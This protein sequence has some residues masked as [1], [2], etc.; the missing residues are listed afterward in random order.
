MTLTGTIL[1]ASGRSTDFD[2]W[3]LHLPS[4]KLVQLTQ[5]ANYNDSPRCSPNGAQI[6]YISVLED[7]I[8]SLWVMD[9][10]GHNK[11]QL[12]KGIYCQHPSWSPDGTKILFTGNAA[13][14]SEIEVCEIAVTGGKPVPL[15][16]RSGIESHPS[17]SPDG[18]TI[19]FAALADGKTSNSDIFEYS[20]SNKTFKQLASHPLKDY[21]PKY[22]PDGK[23]IAFIS[24]RNETTEEQHRTLLE[25]AAKQVAS[26]DMKAL[27]DSIRALQAIESD[28]DIFTMNRDGSDLQQITH[29]SKA[30]QHVSWSPCGKYLVYTSTS[31]KQPQ[32]KRLKVIDAHTGDSCEIDYDRT[33]LKRETGSTSAVNFSIF[34]RVVPDC[35][36]RLFADPSFWGEERHP[37]WIR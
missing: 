28:G 34:Q 32:S 10:D 7:S 6:V 14:P 3:S 27:N 35:I 2:I 12:T 24:H 33:S 21:G 25:T 4:R 8:P 15:F 37:C 9:V 30:D 19:L 16:K 20:P 18:R 36:E 22:S 23:K 17:W 26:G 5:G 11:R 1:F 13:D 29:N 31:M